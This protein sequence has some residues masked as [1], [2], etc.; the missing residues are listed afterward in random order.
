MLKEKFA[1]MYELTGMITLSS[2]IQ[3]R[4]TDKS[5]VDSLA[6]TV[7]WNY[8]SMAC[9]QMVVQLFKGH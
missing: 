5:L 8:D 6:R 2:G 9:P 7:V 4:A 3:T 1:K